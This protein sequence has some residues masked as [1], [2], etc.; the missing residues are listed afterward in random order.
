MTTSR[1]V[2]RGSLG[3]PKTTFNSAKPVVTP[4]AIFGG[5]PGTSLRVGDYVH[6]KQ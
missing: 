6:Y 4:P 2:G 3:A 1:N 5:K